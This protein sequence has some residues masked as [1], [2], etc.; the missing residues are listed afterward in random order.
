MK[1]TVLFVLFS[2]NT[3]GASSKLSCHSVFEKSIDDFIDSFEEQKKVNVQATRIKMEK[4][5]LTKKEY[6]FENGDHLFS[7]AKLRVLVKDST[8]IK[9]QCYGICYQEGFSSKMENLYY[10]KFSKEKAL[11]RLPL[12][13]KTLR[14]RIITEKFYFSTLK[15]SINPKNVL[16]NLKNKPDELQREIFIDFLDKI[17]GGGLLFNF[18]ANDKLY[19]VSVKNAKKLVEF[20]TVSYRALESILMN[21]LLE[22]YQHVRKS[23]KSNE[24]DSEIVN[25]I[26]LKLDSDLVELEKMFFEDF[27]KEFFFEEVRQTDL[28]GP[29]HFVYEAINISKFN[30]IK[31]LDLRRRNSTRIGKSIPLDGYLINDYKTLLINDWKEKIDR[32]EYINISMWWKY[33]EKEDLD[34]SIESPF[35]KYRQNVNKSSHAVMLA[36]YQLDKKDRVSHWIIRNTHGE[37]WAVN[38]YKKIAVDEFFD[39]FKGFYLLESN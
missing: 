25:E 27:A 3:L 32:N 18:E 16:S 1:L 20:E 9:D 34:H 14:S 12:L 6:I 22:Y 15:Y 31:S 17:V 23:F 30:K 39:L 11:F 26:L 36:G 8:P 35:R 19:F 7:N 21:S 13:L 24:L 29:N 10:N 33:L 2:L 28:M 4:T 37:N 5:F 38:G